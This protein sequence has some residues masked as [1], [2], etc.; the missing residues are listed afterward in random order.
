MPAV[1]CDTSAAVDAAFAFACIFPI[2][3]IKI[4]I[5][6][7]MSAITTINSVNVKAR[8]KRVR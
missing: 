3:G 2:T 7:T 8:R 1:N 5:R 6:I 4:P